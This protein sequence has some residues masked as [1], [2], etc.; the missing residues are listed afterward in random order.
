MPEP[1]RPGQRR[2]RSPDEAEAEIVS[3]ARELLAGRPYREVNVNDLMAMTTLSRPSFYQYFPDMQQLMVRVMDEV[4]AELLAVSDVW[5][6]GKGDTAVE[7]KEALLGLARAY[8]QNRALMQAAAAAAATD[9]AMDVAYGNLLNLFIEATTV[10]IKAD[11][12]HG[13]VVGLDPGP[14]ARA[15]V[16]MTE[17]VLLDQLATSRARRPEVVVEPLLQV[18]LRTLYLRDAG[19]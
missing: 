6:K 3:A 15:L 4:G 2:R 16:L 9:P 10:R 19:Q 11:K 12:A 8:S 13:L 18:W 5:L 17:R 14:T 1:A 7:A